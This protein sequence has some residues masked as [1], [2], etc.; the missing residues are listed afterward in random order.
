[1]DFEMPILNLFCLAALCVVVSHL[2]D[3][4][5]CHHYTLTQLDADLEF[6]SKHSSWRK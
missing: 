3:V 5:L 2:P 1:M 4:L 6:T